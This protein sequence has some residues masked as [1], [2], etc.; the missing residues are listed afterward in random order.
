LVDHIEQA[1]AHGVTTITTPWSITVH[2]LTLAR[3]SH[4]RLVAPGG[5]ENKQTATPNGY[6]PT[7]PTGQPRTNTRHHTEK[8]LT[9]DDQDDA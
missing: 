6:P 3:G 5:L 1:A 2:N 9:N 7:R 8:F 4:R